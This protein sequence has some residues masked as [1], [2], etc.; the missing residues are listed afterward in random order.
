MTLRVG[1]IGCGAIADGHVEEVAKIDG[2]RVAAVCDREII[3]AEQLADRYGPF[4]VYDDAAAMLGAESLDVVH[5]TTPPQSHFELAV[6]AIDAGCHVLVEKPFTLTAVDAVSLIDRANATDR[7]VAVGHFYQF[8]PPALAIRRLVGRGALGTVCHLESHY[9][10][11]LDGAFGRGIMGN[12]SH[13][14]HGL[15]GNLLQNNISHPLSKVIEFMAG[16]P[17]VLGAHAVRGEAGRFGDVRDNLFRELRAVLRAGDVTATVTFTSCAR[18]VMHALRVYGTRDSVYGDFVS[19]TVTF[20]RRSALP[21]AIGRLVSTFP[22]GWEYHRE[23]WKNVYRFLRSRYHFQAGMNE[24]FRRFYRSIRDGDAPPVPYR[25]IV[26]TA[27]VMDAI[28]DAIVEE[29]ENP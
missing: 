7:R 24:L 19:R 15:R 4:P 2:A 13:W 23:G 29:G 9:G 18:P 14:V 27:R 1:I 20:E 28:F 25:E 5:I 17:E 12:P 6:Q 10:Y 11:N 21:G 22:R 16:E 3:M 26:A 8:D